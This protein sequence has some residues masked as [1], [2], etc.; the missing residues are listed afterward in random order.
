MLFQFL[1]D[2]AHEGK[3]KDYGYQ[4][5]QSLVK[6]LLKSFRSFLLDK[7]Y[8]SG[9]RLVF[10]GS[11]M[12]AYANRT[13]LTREGIDKKLENLDKS[14]AEYLSQLENNDV[15]DDELETAR[16]E[17]KEL[18]ERIEKL[19]RQ[20]AKFE[21][22]GKAL[23]S[24]GKKHISPNDKDAVLVKGRDGKFAGYNGQ[25]GV[26][27]KGHFIMHNEIRPKPMTSNNWKIVLIR[28][29]QKWTKK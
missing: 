25:A 10:D 24:S 2:P 17:I 13:M 22:A 26:E 23:E 15:H 6:E 3:H 21:A 20:K 1:V 7:S 12:K 16:D 19:E 27:S 14:I 9:K 4:I 28:Q 11:K 8:A 29:K 5:E 18:K